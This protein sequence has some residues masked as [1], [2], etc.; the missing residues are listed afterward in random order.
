MAR[1]L[2]LLLR[3]LGTLVRLDGINRLSF[4]LAK[5]VM[6][7]AIQV[8]ERVHLSVQICIS[9]FQVDESRLQ[10]WRRRLAHQVAT[11]VEVLRAS[12]QIVCHAWRA[13]A[14]SLS[15]V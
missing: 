11:G 13:D 8:L 10:I 7:V 6:K 14:G 15:A 4:D 9:P 12:I 2:Q 5:G 1:L 3:Q